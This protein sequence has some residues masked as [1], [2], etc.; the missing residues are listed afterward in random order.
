MADDDADASSC[1]GP[2]DHPI[3]MAINGRTSRGSP[4]SGCACHVSCAECGFSSEPTSAS[5]CIV[6]ADDDATFTQSADWD[7][8]RTGSCSIDASGAATDDIVI[9]MDTLI[10]VGV[11]VG[12]TIAFLVSVLVVKTLC[13]PKHPKVVDSS[14]GMIE[15]HCRHSSDDVEQPP[16]KH[17]RSIAFDELDALSGEDEDQLSPL[18]PFPNKLERVRNHDHGDDF[19]VVDNDFDRDER[20]EQVRHHRERAR[21][22]SVSSSCGGSRRVRDGRS[23]SVSSGGSYRGSGGGGDGGGSGRLRSSSVSSSSHGRISR[24]GSVSGGS[25]GSR[26]HR[27]RSVSGGSSR[28]DG[29][30]PRHSSHH[31]NGSVSGGGER[32]PSSSSH[33]SVSGSSHR[34]S[35]LRSVSGSSSHRSH[36]SD[37]MDR[38]GGRHYEDGS[39]SGSGSE[40][41]ADPSA[42]MRRA[43]EE[44]NAKRQQRRRE[45]EAEASKRDGESSASDDGETAEEVIS[46]YEHEEDRPESTAV[47]AP[48]S[49]SAGQHNRGHSK[50]SGRSKRRQSRRQLPPSSSEEEGAGGQ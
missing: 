2:D 3:V 41:N 46:R 19:V 15:Q 38:E 13:C 42:D 23:R 14:P 24:S 5:S 40:F 28:H 21:S 10:M 33:R 16:S 18:A 34:S 37:T 27:S 49:P 29:G 44:H 12:G 36:R 22:H 20:Y 47:S 4:I 43:V 35:R 9:T 1:F 31:R 26:H 11:A 50:S 45:R 48:T 8:S 30:T 39:E 6:C 25:S 32:S 7:T 17:K